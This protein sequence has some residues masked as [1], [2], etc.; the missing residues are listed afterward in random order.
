[1]GVCAMRATWGDCVIFFCTGTLLAVEEG[2]AVV[3]SAESARVNLDCLGQ[4][5]SYGHPN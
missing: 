3:N 1:M 5:E 2:D 4:A